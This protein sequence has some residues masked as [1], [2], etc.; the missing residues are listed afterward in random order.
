MYTRV[1]F[2]AGFLLFT[3][4]LAPA[5]AGSGGEPMVTGKIIKF[6]SGI[7][8]EER[9]IFISLPAGY[10]NSSERHPVLYCLTLEDGTDVHYAG[11]VARK[12]ADAGIVPKMIV[13]GLCDV[14]GR[15]DLTP[16]HSPGY[17]PT[18]G[19][20]TTYLEHLEK[21]VVPFIEKEYRTRAPRIFWGHSI[22]GALGIYGFLKSPGLCNAY[23][24]SSPYFVYDGREQYL[25]KNTESFL[26]KRSIEKN[27]LHLTVGNEPQLK[28]EIESFIGKLEALKPP[29][30]QWTYSVKKDE[31]HRSVMAV[32]LPDGLRAVFTEW[33]D[34]PSR[35]S[36]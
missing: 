10:E 32:V 35:S 14:D 18:S 23:V 5:P 4:G 12:M 13:V 34:P 29:G 20:A 19:G 36:R 6:E 3:S 24:L 8:G 27:F 17:G 2:L 7:L 31:D 28:G 16:T 15:R 25:L 22:V 21:E 9:R 11:G 26:E 33:E 1:L 30:V